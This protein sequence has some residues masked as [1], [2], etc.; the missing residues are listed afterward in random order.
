[1]EST[2]NSRLHLEL[3]LAITVFGA[4]VT[5]SVVTTSLPVLP[6]LLGVD[7][8]SGMF[9]VNSVVPF[10]HALFPL[11][12]VYAV[13]RRGI[14]F[15]V[16][17]WAVVMISLTAA[18]LG[19][20]VG[21]SIGYALLGRQL[22]TPLVL[23][24]SADLAAREFGVVMWVGVVLGVFGAGLWGTVGTLGGIGFFVHSSDSE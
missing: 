9:L 23:V 15:P 1:M 6:Q 3:V 22:P 13:R 21:T 2:A 19:R 16:S 11:G 7:M 4:T 8:V 20:Y 24:S 14:G 17:T 5:A 18:V 10:I 12:F